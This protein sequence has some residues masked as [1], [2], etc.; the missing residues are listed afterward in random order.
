MPLESALSRLRTQSL[1]KTMR[2]STPCRKVFMLVRM[3]SNGWELPVLQ[4]MH[5]LPCAQRAFW[6]E[7]YMHTLPCV[8]RAFWFELIFNHNSQHVV[9]NK[10][11]R[12]PSNLLSNFIFICKFK[13]SQSGGQ[14]KKVISILVTDLSFFYFVHVFSY[15]GLEDFSPWLPELY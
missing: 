13:Q 4:Y 8:Q 6:F 11:Y 14:K 1:Q 9:I 7:Q 12:F 5:T 15:H 10:L 2:V 3:Q